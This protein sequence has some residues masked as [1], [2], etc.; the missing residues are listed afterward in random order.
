[1]SF[2]VA[3]RTSVPADR[4]AGWLERFAAGHGQLSSSVCRTRCC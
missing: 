3:H 1:M 2:E 4:L